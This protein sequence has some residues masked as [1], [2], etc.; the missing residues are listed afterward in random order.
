MSFAPFNNLWRK[1]PFMPYSSSDSGII[2]LPAPSHP[3]LQKLR[4]ALVYAGFVLPYSG[5]TVPGFH[6]ILLY[7]ILG[8]VIQRFTA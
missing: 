4:R 1:A 6:G 3:P 2:L 7:H 5:E 8:D